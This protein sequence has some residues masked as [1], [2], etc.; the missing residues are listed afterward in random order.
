MSN[1][2]SQ[3]QDSS[4]HLAFPDVANL[5]VLTRHVVT[6]TSSVLDVLSQTDQVEQCKLIQVLSKL[7]AV[8]MKTSQVMMLNVEEDR[9]CEVDDVAMLKSDPQTARLAPALQALKSS[10]RDVSLF[11]ANVPQETLQTETFALYKFTTATDQLETIY[12]TE[13]NKALDRWKACLEVVCQQLTSVTPS[14]WKDKALDSYDKTFIDSRILVQTLITGLGTDYP[15]ACA[16]LTALETNSEPIMTAFTERWDKEV[17]GFKAILSDTRDL[18]SCILAYNVMQNKFPKA[19]A[20]DRRQSFKDLKKKLKSKF[21]KTYEM[22]A[23]IA[24]RV[25]AAINDK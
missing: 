3:C 2:V 25:Q 16:C 20:A 17:K 6:P 9:V 13:L 5:E 10:T 12:T 14:D 8:Q 22:P 24:D 15:P 23:K 18:V 21:G 1:R 4:R 7:E 11:L 19:T